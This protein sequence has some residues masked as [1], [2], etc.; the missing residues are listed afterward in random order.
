MLV[1]RRGGMAARESCKGQ[2]WVGVSPGERGHVLRDETEE[3]GLS[4]AGQ[5][6]RGL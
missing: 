5:P 2:R 3:G 4:Q 1:N 6:G